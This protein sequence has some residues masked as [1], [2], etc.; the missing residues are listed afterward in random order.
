MKNDNNEILNDQVEQEVK[1]FEEENNLNIPEEEGIEDQQQEKEEE[2][3]GGKFKSVDDLLKS[4][5]ELEKKL[6][7]PKEEETKEE[8]G[9]EKV[10]DKPLEDLTI[11]PKE[12]EEKV[13]AEN[14]EIDP[15]S[16]LAELASKQLQGEEIS[17][18]ELKAAG[19]SKKVFDYYMKGIQAETQAKAQ[20]IMSTVGGEENYKA[21]LEWAKDNISEQEIDSYNNII[22]SGD[23]GAIKLATAGLKMQ[24]DSANG[25]TGV[26]V[27]EAT[28]LAVRPY[29]SSTEYINDVQKALKDP[30][31]Q[32]IVDKRI[33]I[34]DLDILL[35]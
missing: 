11:P 6:G 27:A 30:N 18:E 10:E 32:K 2:L 9:K 5:K 8:E 15:D 17:E 34:T 35:D 25:F 26:G 12:E 28:G 3:I 16:K 31:Y 4:Y 23:V 7:K 14:N 21:L 19:V 33:E 13:E 24:Y 1:Q 20:A 22:K 29:K